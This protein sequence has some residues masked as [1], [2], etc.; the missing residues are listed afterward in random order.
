MSQRSWLL[1]LLVFCFFAGLASGQTIE[2]VDTY[3][4]QPISQAHE[5]SPVRLRATDGSSAGL[6]SL[7]VRITSDLRGDE[8]WVTLW[9][10]ANNPGVFISSVYALQVLGTLTTD[11]PSQDGLFQ[12]T[13]YAGPPLQRDT[14]RAFLESCSTPPCPTDAV[15]MI[16]STIRLT[17][18]ERVDV[19]QAVPGSPLYIAV[20]DHGAP[21][22][23]PTTATVV[24]Q[25]GDSETV[26][27]PPDFSDPDVP[28]NAFRQSI[29]VETGPAV[30]GDG[31]LQVQ[32]L[33]T[34]TASH[35]DPLGLSFSTDSA[36]VGTRPIRFLD[37]FSNP[38]DYQFENSPVR[39][40]AVH[41]DGNTDP[42]AADAVTA[43]LL[44]KD[45]EGNTRDP[46]TLQ[47]TETGPDTGVFTGQ[48][49]H[50]TYYQAVPGNGRLESWY[51]YSGPSAPSF[52]D[53]VTVVLDSASATVPFLFSKVW[54]IDAAG[55]E[56]TQYS[57]GDRIYMRVEWEWA[58][59]TPS[60]AQ[61][62]AVEVRSLTTGDSEFAALY[63]TGPDT[64]VF[65]GW[66]D[67]AE[68]PAAWDNVLGVQT[69]ETIEMIHNGYL[70]Q[71]KDQAV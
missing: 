68:L 54:F 34:I 38:V 11:P 40:R 29:A 47:L 3:S 70:I 62:I 56:A 18:S 55:N 60:Q 49:E 7:L 39:V 21:Y 61:S 69:G 46:E 67:S 13:E 5:F 28:I 44:T 59:S 71:V 14:I 23:A 31:V 45:I 57:I 50:M 35:P 25:S 37:R 12:V 15:P 65:E 24:S 19:D 58:N 6:G 64:A 10:D 43:T 30:P 48:I 1:S 22:W 8:E 36:A 63:E 66:I 9:E 26:S 51:T 17:D 41:P 2:W 4:G 16:G 53:L 27:L 52:S 33:D 42:G 32:E 20:R